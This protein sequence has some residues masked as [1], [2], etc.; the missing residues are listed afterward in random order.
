MLLYI[1]G[2]YL[3]QI[4]GTQIHCTSHQWQS[5]KTDKCFWVKLLN[6]RVGNLLPK[7]WSLWKRYNNIIDTHLV[8]Q[9]TL[10]ELLYRC[11][12]STYNISLWLSPQKTSG[13]LMVKIRE[14]NRCSTKDNFIIQPEQIVSSDRI[15]EIV[16]P[17]PFNQQSTLIADDNSFRNLT[18]QVS[19]YNRNL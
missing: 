14:I 8:H 9:R 4:D 7:S 1:I 2:K 17:V 18:D 19:W 5:L 6:W 12:Y 3:K 10:S 15:G 16:N 13:L 11:C